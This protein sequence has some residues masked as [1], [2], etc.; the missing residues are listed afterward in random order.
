MDDI[1]IAECGDTE[2][3]ARQ[4]NQQKLQKVYQRCAVKTIV[5][6][7]ANQEIN[8]HGHR[9]TKDGLLVD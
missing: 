7:E 8:L 9:I 3:L 6:N 1:V 4:D 2:E 5:L